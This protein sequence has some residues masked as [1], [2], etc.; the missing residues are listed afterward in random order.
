[1]HMNAHKDWTDIHSPTH[2]NLCL[3]NPE[4]KVTDLTSKEF[5]L[6]L[7]ITAQGPIVHEMLDTLEFGYPECGDRGCDWR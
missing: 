4:R 5:A 1:L 6:L 7:V 2:K 3:W